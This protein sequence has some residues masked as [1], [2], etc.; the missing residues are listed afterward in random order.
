MI[1]KLRYSHFTRCP[2]CGGWR[3]LDDDEIACINCAYKVMV[4]ISRTSP[5]LKFHYEQ[6]GVKNNV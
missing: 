3:Y 2:K 4:E 1:N 6:K 5:E